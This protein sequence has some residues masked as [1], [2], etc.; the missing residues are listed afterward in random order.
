MTPDSNSAVVGVITNS[1]LNNTALY[2]QM[3]F[4]EPK[5]NQ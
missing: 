5:V 1:N 4:L 2:L 3:F